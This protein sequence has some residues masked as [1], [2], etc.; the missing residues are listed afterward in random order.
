MTSKQIAVIQS[1]FIVVARN[2]E[3]FTAQFYHRLLRDNP[4]M[5]PIFATANIARQQR[6]LLLALVTIVE[7]LDDED[8]LRENLGELGRMHDNMNIDQNLFDIFR[9]AFI[10]TLADFLKQ[11]WNDDIQHAWVTGFDRIIQIM[12]DESQTE[13]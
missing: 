9:D 2:R 7:I 8:A 6:K 13:N 11:D 1:T 10:A 3:G 4:V 12:M 5:R